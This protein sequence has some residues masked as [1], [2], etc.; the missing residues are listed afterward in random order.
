MPFLARSFLGNSIQAWLVALVVLVGG[1]MLLV[2]V[3]RLLVQRLE[4]SASHTHTRFDDI[5]LGALR[6][7]SGAFL[8]AVALVAAEHFALELPPNA[9]FALHLFAKLALLLQAASWGTGAIALWLDRTTRRA[10]QDKATVTT[11]NIIGILARVVLWTLVLLLALRAF[12]VDIT[13]LVTGLGIAG[14]AVAL[15]VQNVLGDLFASLSIALDKPFVIGDTIKVDE[16]T[17]TVEDIGL[18]TT[19]LRALTGELLIFSNADLLK[20]RIRNFR[21]QVQRRVQFTLGVAPDTPPDRLARVPALVREIIAAEPQA[22]F[23]R[24]HVSA[25][26]DSAF[27]VESVYFVT[28]GDYGVYMDMQQRIYLTLLRR[29][30][31][32]KVQLARPAPPVVVLRDDG[33]RERRSARAQE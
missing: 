13:A 21:G 18:K 1:W 22:R 11:L 20:S 24:S 26:G 28:T 19:R 32:E 14:I 15:A 27:G 12:Q 2:V 8:L 23:D 9:E 30:A 31:D 6:R 7:T 25:I 4:R 5:A 29:L 10:E 33:I 17:G 3:R 16:F